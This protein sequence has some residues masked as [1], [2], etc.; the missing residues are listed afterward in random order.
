MQ[1]ERQRSHEP[2]YVG[3]R[4]RS[5][6]GVWNFGMNKIE[7]RGRQQRTQRNICQCGEAQNIPGQDHALAD[8]VP[9]I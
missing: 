8:A 2:G 9:R 1:H 4:K 5:N 7:G 3:E 6:R